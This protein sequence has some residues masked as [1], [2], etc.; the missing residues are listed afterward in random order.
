M[1]FAHS[2]TNS[3][4]PPR[5]RWKVPW[6][7]PVMAELLVMQKEE[8][9]SREAAITDGVP[10]PLLINSNGEVSSLPWPTDGWPLAVANPDCV[11]APVTMLDLEREAADLHDRLGL[12]VA[13]ICSKPG[14]VVQMDLRKANI[15]VLVKKPAGRRVV[16]AWLHGRGPT[17]AHARAVVLQ[18][19]W[20]KDAHF[21]CPAR[22]LPPGCAFVGCSTPSQTKRRRIDQFA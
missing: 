18:S 20:F 19:P 7:G 14:G 22:L 8:G 13:K 17:A 9:V 12:Q 4:L 21:L 1:V 16:N 2:C 15:Q 11:D 5:S 3:S 10:M 6:N